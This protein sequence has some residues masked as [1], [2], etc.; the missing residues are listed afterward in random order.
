VNL[1]GWRAHR[2]HATVTGVLTHSERQPERPR[3][4][5]GDDTGS[6]GRRAGQKET[7]ARRRVGI[8]CGVAGSPLVPRIGVQRLSHP[9]G[10]YL[11]LLD[12]LIEHGVLLAEGGLESVQ[13]A[14]NVGAGA[15]GLAAI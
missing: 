11:R 9:H 3:C 1:S 8:H 4:R 7:P 14:R 12:Q 13:R 6:A 2:D 10:A 15:A 5:H